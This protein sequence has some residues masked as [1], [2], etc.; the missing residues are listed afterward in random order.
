[1]ELYTQSQYKQLIKNGQNRDKDHYPVI[2]LFM[3][4][5]AHTWLITE[6]DP[7]EPDIAFGLCDLGIGFPEL[8]Y[9]SLEEISSVKNRYGFSVERDLHFEAKY[10]ISVYTDAARFHSRIVE[11]SD[12]LDRFNPKKP[13]GCTPS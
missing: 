5:M 9:V 2:K 4:G 1:M 11:S 3:P 10:P 6:L 8:G 12:K 13:G 7:E